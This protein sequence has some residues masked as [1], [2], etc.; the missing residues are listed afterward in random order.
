MKLID[1][2]IKRA[3]NEILPDKIIFQNNIFHFNGDFYSN[4]EYKKLED[5]CYLSSFLNDEIKIIETEEKPKG[6]SM[7]D[8]Y[9]LLY[10]E[11]SLREEET[12]EAINEL[13]DKVNEIIKHINGD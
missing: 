8:K 12:A 9:Q 10:P 1:L 4:E 11:G 6:I 7:I 5:Y 2:L 3:N 13:Q